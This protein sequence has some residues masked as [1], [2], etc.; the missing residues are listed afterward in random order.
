M[1][2]CCNIARNALVTRFSIR[3]LRVLR[4]PIHPVELSRCGTGTPSRCELPA[5]APT[6][7]LSP[8]STKIQRKA[9]AKLLQAA[10]SSARGQLNAV[11]IHAVRTGARN[12][13]MFAH[14]FIN[15]ESD[16]ACWGARSMQEAH[17]LGA[18]NMLNPAAK[19]NSRM[20]E[21]LFAV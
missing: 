3:L 1:P 13:A 20:A 14:M 4:R 8:A 17:Q 18:A 7:K 16:P 11:A 5:S 6:S 12:P 19:A 9:A 10:K 15:P 2:G 21:T